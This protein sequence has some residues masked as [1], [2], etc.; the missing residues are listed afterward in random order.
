LII[1]SIAILSFGIF[2]DKKFA[3]RFDET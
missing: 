2:L 1:A 3:V